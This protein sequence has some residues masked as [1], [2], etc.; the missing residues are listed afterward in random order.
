MDTVAAESGL[1]TALV[2]ILVGGVLGAV[3]TVLVTYLTPLAQRRDRYDDALLT[4]R[5]QSYERL[6][7]TLRPTSRFH[8]AE[9]VDPMALATNLTAWYYD[10]GDG[11]YMSRD[12]YVQFFRLRDGLRGQPPLSHEEVIELGSTM[13]QQITTDLNSRKPPLLAEGT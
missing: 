8:A 13:R 2:S 7:A 10:N 9:P 11:I 4:R 12:M 5:M 3:T 1:S 6:Q